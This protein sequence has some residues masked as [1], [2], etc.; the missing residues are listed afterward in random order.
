MAHYHMPKP[1]QKQINFPN[2]I[3][4]QNFPQFK[5]KQKNSLFTGLHQNSTTVLDVKNS[6]AYIRG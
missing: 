5:V 4:P 3:T 6:K 1:N 2:L